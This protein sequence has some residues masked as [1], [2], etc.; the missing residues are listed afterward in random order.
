MTSMLSQMKAKISKVSEYLENR[1]DSSLET[2]ITHRNFKTPIAIN[3]E[4]RREMLLIL[5]D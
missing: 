2:S 5:M 1:L 4:L 3:A